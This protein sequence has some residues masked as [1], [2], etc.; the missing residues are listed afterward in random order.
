VTDQASSALARARLEEMQRRLGAAV[1]QAAEAVVITDTGSRILYA[2]PAF[3]QI[4]GLTRAE[5]IGQTSEWLDGGD[6]GDAS[7]TRIWDMLSS[8]QSW[9]GRVTNTRPDGSVYI[10]DVDVSPVRNQAGE[11]INYVATLRDITREVQLEEQFQQAQ[12]M[13]ALGRLAGGIAHDFNN[14]LTVIQLSTRLLDLQLRPEDPLW[15]HA[16]QIRH[17]GVQAGK[18]TKQL[19]SFSRREVID[20]RVLSLSLVVEDLSRMLER[21]I[22]EDI[23][24]VTDL[25][26]D[27]W[28]IKADLAQMEQVIMNLV[29]NARDAMP[30]G[31]T[32]TIQT[33]NVTLDHAYAALHVDT[34]PGDHVLLAI[35]DTGE[36]MS[37]AVKTH[38]FEPFFTTKERGQ[39]TGLGLSTVFGTIK[40]ADGHIDV[41]S[42]MDRGT[43]FKIYLPRSREEITAPESPRRQKLAAPL[44]SRE[45]VLV[46]EDDNHVRQLIFRVLAAQGYNVLQASSG[47]QALEI[48]AAA[49]AAIDL[50]VTDIVMPRMKGTELAE[51]MQ[52]ERPSLAVLYISGYADG[53]ILPRGSLPS[54]IKFL[55]KPFAV[56]DLV[57]KVRDLLVAR[58]DGSGLDQG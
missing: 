56:E 15:E 43:T 42:E 54:D 33:S 23:E 48:S 28:P 14:L 24:L 37:S 40:Q 25:A 38:L 6:R 3:E 50:L 7:G 12:K 8:G 21:I 47:E 27:L 26:D 39:G 9:Q 30:S 20:P 17:A 11:M 49:K 45:T 4:T 46:V 55:P 53:A 18:L 16:Q 36:G 35:S 29:V 22:G 44:A 58:A 5:V 13:E 19:L 10:V 31:G 1:E 34:S 57:R 41:E 2:N 52:L 51:R 32:L